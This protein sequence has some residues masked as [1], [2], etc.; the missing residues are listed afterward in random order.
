MQLRNYLPWEII[1]R[2]L[3]KIIINKIKSSQYFGTLI[4][5]KEARLHTLFH[6]FY[7]IFDLLL[8]GLRAFS[9]GDILS[10]TLPLHE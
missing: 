2:W 3:K 9:R 1:Y 10:M 4:K 6:S 8:F 5:V 7:F